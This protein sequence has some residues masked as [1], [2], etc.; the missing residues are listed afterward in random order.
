MK[1]QLELRLET[2][3]PTERLLQLEVSYAAPA[4]LRVGL[5]IYADGT[6]WDPGSGEGLYVYKST[7]WAAL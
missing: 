5:I 2:V 3:I 7:G 4:K 1:E 6:V